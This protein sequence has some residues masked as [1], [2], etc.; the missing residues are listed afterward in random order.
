MPLFCHFV[1]ATPSAT[2][3][4][5]ERNQTQS[6]VFFFVRWFCFYWVTYHL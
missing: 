6:G 3:L 2:G 1:I 4:D 5:L